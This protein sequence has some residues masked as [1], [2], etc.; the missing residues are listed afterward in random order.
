[1]F[2]QHPCSV[3]W[4]LISARN[5]HSGVSRRQKLISDTETFKNF[6]QGNAP[7]LYEARVLDEWK[8]LWAQRKSQDRNGKTISML[9]PPPNITGNLHLGHVLTVSVQDV[10]ARWYHMQGFNVVWIPGTDHAGIATQV[11]VEK[12]LKK[13]G[14]SRHNLGRD[15]FINRVKKWQ[16]DKGGHITE[17][18]TKLGLRLD[19][20]REYFTMDEHQTQAVKHAIIQLFDDELLYRENALVN[21]C[22]VLKSTISDVEV[23]HILVEGKTELKVPGYDKPV[24]FGQL[25]NFAY[26]VCDSDEE[27]VV[28]TTRP[29]TILGDVAIAVNPK[30]SR[31][32]HLHRAMVQHPF[33]DSKLPIVLDETVEIEFGTGAMKVTPAHD[34]TDFQISRKHKLPIIEI[35]NEDGTLKENCGEYKGLK[36]FDARKK[37]IE[38]LDSKGLLR[39]VQD[40]EMSIP[41]CS[42]TRDVIE[43]ILKPQWF[44][45]CKQM[46]EKALEVVRTGE[47]TIEPSNHIPAWNIWFENTEAWC[48]SRQ[49]WWGHRLPLYHCEHGWVAAH[50]VEEAKKKAEAKWGTIT[51]LEQDE[52]VLDTWFSSA[53]LPFSSVGWPNTN[54][55]DFQQ[56]YPLTFMETGHDILCF[57]VAR[58]VMLGSF[59]TGQLPFSKVILHGMI[60]DSQ[61][62]KMSKSL[63]NTIEPEHVVAGI[64]L[65]DLNKTLKTSLD[66]GVIT[67]DEYQTSLK[68]QKSLFPQGIPECGTDALRYTLCS[69]TVSNTIVHFDPNTCALNKRFGNKILN[70]SKFTCCHA[71]LLG[72]TEIQCPTELSP[73]TVPERWI[74]SRL[75][76]TISEVNTSLESFNVHLAARSL[77]DFLYGDLCDIFVELSKYLL[78]SEDDRVCLSAGNTLVTS[79]DASLRLMSP[80]M[81]F[82]M[83]ILYKYLPRR[84]DQ[85][86]SE[87]SYPL[88]LDWSHWRDATLEEEIAT[89]L[90]VVSAIR[91]IT[92][93]N[94]IAGKVADVVITSQDHT[95]LSKHSDIL[96]NLVRTKSLLITSPGDSLGDASADLKKE[97]SNSFTFSDTVSPSTSVHIIV[98][99][100][101]KSVTQHEKLMR[102]KRKRLK[103]EIEKTM[104]LMSP[105]KRKGKK[106]LPEH[107]QEGFMNKL[108][109]LQEEL[110]QVETFLEMAKDASR[111]RH[112]DQLSKDQQNG[113]S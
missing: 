33:S 92:S 46:G 104:K 102:D 83:H 52:D 112:A 24:V 97:E 95:V 36:R 65:Q 109:S 73:L 43:L 30:D 69:Q 62:R 53:L 1:M 98:R 64:S 108:N 101:E 15:A 12:S 76:N 45:D 57:W 111:I 18:L 22:C 90:D 20:S 6:I 59:F 61:G 7:A 26:K 79:L 60:C 85:S 78:A 66:A 89:V 5:I 27:I 49:L 4:C 28:S 96:S 32:A 103:K 99:N 11:V 113:V 93:V 56:L 50:D 17:Q 29:E 13:E 58:M 87:C 2:W 10:L 3:R 21:W 74:L 71:E 47:L 77:K 14:L 35:I 34:K 16:Q 67:A 25:Y 110:S 82:L 44:L 31:Y 88:S 54:S 81:P 55:S 100:S 105:E 41:V 72:I 68:T 23:D 38:D 9:L 75:A 70:L 63:G 40:H 48:I 91:R 106:P 42:R 86:V 80:F 94:N 37:I 19:W 84:S 39:S 51:M 107:V 8:T